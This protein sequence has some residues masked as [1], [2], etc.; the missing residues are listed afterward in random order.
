MRIIRNFT[1]S[2][3]FL[4]FNPFGNGCLKCENDASNTYINVRMPYSQTSCVKSLSTG[5]GS[6]SLSPKY[7]VGFCNKYTHDANF[8]IKCSECQTGY[9]HSNDRKYCVPDTTVNKCKR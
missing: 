6:D 3:D 8:G 9:R 2:F 1:S 4:G 5:T 7:Y